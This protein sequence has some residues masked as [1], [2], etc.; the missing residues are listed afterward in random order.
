MMAFSTELIANFLPGSFA[1]VMATGIVS[2]AAHGFGS[3]PR[4][5]PSSWS[6][7]SH[8]PFYGVL[9]WPG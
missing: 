5:F 2:L 6:T 7:S 1:F 4:H 3:T 8:S 9:R